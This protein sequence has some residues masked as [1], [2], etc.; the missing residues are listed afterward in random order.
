MYNK[1]LKIVAEVK[2]FDKE[3]KYLLDDISKKINYPSLN[4]VLV[5]E[6]K[7]DIECTY[8]NGLIFDGNKVILDESKVKDKN[9]LSLTDASVKK[10]IGTLT[11]ESVDKSY[12][13]DV[14][15]ETE[16]LGTINIDQIVDYSD[17]LKG[18]IKFYTDILTFVATTLRHAL[19]NKATVFFQPTSDVSNELYFKDKQWQATE[20]GTE[21]KYFLEFINE[22]CS[23]YFQ[24]FIKDFLASMKLIDNKISYSIVRILSDGYQK[25]AAQYFT[26]VEFKNSILSDI[27]YSYKAQLID[28]N[29]LTKFFDLIPNIESSKDIT[30]IKQK[31]LKDISSLLPK[32]VNNINNDYLYSLLKD[33]KVVND[34]YEY[35]SLW[36]KKFVESLNKKEFKNKSLRNRSNIYN[37]F[38]KLIVAKTP[39]QFKNQVNKFEYKSN[40]YKLRDVLSPDSLETLQQYLKQVELDDTV[41][42]DEE[43]TASQLNDIIDN[44]RKSDDENI[45]YFADEL[46]ELL[47][48]EDENESEFEE[49]KL[50]MDYQEKYN[51]KKEEVK[52][53]VARELGLNINYDTRDLDEDTSESDRKEYETEVNKRMKEFEDSQK[54]NEK[55]SKEVYESAVL[56]DDE[57]TAMNSIFAPAFKN[58]E[59][60]KQ[61]HNKSIE[62]IFRLQRLQQEINNTVSNNS[63]NDLRVVLLSIIKRSDLPYYIKSSLHSVLTTKLDTLQMQIDYLNALL[64]IHL[65]IQRIFSESKNYSDARKRIGTELNRNRDMKHYFEYGA[66]NQ[67]LSHK[68]KNVAPFLEHDNLVLM[69]KFLQWAKEDLD[70]IYE[71]NDENERKFQEL[72]EKFNNKFSVNLKINTKKDLI[73]NGNI[74][75][76][77]VILDPEIDKLL[78]DVNMSDASNLNVM[79]A[80]SFSDAIENLNIIYTYL[81]KEVEDLKNNLNIRNSN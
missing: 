9:N 63:T 47:E 45:L 26:S 62:N 68:R 71:D 6:G 23:N 48:R 80:K 60:Y 43:L 76:E 79:Q 39:E 53:Q 28:I 69:R 50:E 12:G 67:D 5:G 32:N 58:E 57:K 73:Y 18:E 72:I 1:F 81:Y 4:F 38:T 51:R 11:Y 10:S 35:V 8:K 65:R 61:F 74:K 3:L 33:A 42:L 78:K 22:S 55:E 49:R 27:A 2:D 31:I 41:K 46:S 20:Y 13:Y 30:A 44:L 17:M 16:D 29:N 25:A 37:R 56:D 77:R 66:I 70:E 24:I 52:L 59:V 54:E 75:E 14:L 21:I 40:I 36:F 19:H 7:Y 34:I 64:T 15:T